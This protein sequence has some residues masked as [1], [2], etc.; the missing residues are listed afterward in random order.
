MFLH[1]L[2]EKHQPR[3]TGEKP[4]KH[5]LAFQR[6][7]VDDFMVCVDRIIVASTCFE[8]VHNGERDR[9]R[10]NGVGIGATNKDGN[11]GESV[12]SVKGN[13]E[14]SSRSLKKVEMVE[15]RI[16][17][18]EDEVL[19]ME[20]P[21][22]CNGTLKAVV[23][24]FWDV[25]FSGSGIFVD[26]SGVSFGFSFN[27][28]SLRGSPVSKNEFA[29]RK[30]IQRW[31]NKKGDITCEICNQV[32]SPNYSLPPASS[33][34]DVMAIDIRQAWGHHIDLHDS[35][36]L[37]LEHQLLQSEYEDYAVANT[38]SIACL[39]SVALILLI[40]L[41]LRQALIITGDSGMVQESS[42]FFSLDPNDI[43]F[44]VGLSVSGFTS[45]ICRF[46][47]AVL[48]DGPI[49]VHCAKPKEETCLRETSTTRAVFTPKE[50]PFRF[51]VFGSD[52]QAP[53]PPVA[54]CQVVFKVIAIKMVENQDWKSILS[55]RVFVK[56]PKNSKRKCKCVKSEFIRFLY[57][58]LEMPSILSSFL[59]DIAR[60]DSPGLNHP[61]D[62]VLELDIH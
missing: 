60:Y 12:V 21:C 18:E 8:S 17:Q 38:S 34:P 13:E 30:C 39:R 2:R 59:L 6:E 41:L 4:S 35:H 37:A 9:N 10:S 48:R 3:R 22:S 45:S 53:L 20:A 7:M 24:C 29:H 36:L 56:L 26:S 23:L 11:V 43:N 32:F 44:D 52:R 14:G 54:I 1:F 58:M 31:C 51:L 28:S 40:V 49:L 57:F 25:G 46:S 5:Q 61:G 55:N 15:C 47:F 42:T 50:T 62:P 27:S 19:A 33:N 16:C